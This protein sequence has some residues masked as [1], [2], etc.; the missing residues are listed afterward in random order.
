MLN[1]IFPTVKHNDAVSDMMSTGVCNTITTANVERGELQ[2]KIG[3]L[4]VNY[5]GELQSH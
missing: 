4:H 2:K 5:P 3:K 1:P